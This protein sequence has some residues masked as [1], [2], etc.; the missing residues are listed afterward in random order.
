M[1]SS[2]SV[3]WLLHELR[4]SDAKNVEPSPSDKRLRGLGEQRRRGASVSV[5]GRI[6]RSRLVWA[7]QDGQPMHTEDP[8]AGRRRSRSG[9]SLE[10]VRSRTSSDALRTI[11]GSRDESYEQKHVGRRPLSASFYMEI[12]SPL[13]GEGG[14]AFGRS[15]TRPGAEPWRWRM[16]DV[17]AVEGSAGRLLSEERPRRCS[18]LGGGEKSG[19]AVTGRIRR[20]LQHRTVV[21]QSVVRL[22]SCGV[23]HLRLGSALVE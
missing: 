7:R 3:R 6:S 5:T 8:R 11:R 21:E 1:R 16:H 15:P 17:E 13:T 23:L 12:F 14:H 22:E 4:P 9:R 20:W 10:L 2:S 19:L 18:Q